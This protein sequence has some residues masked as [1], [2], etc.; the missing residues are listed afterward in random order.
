ME[1]I[2]RGYRIHYQ[3]WGQGPP[4]LLVPG[5]LLRIES[6]L[7]T[8]IPQQF[9]TDWRVLILDPLGQGRSDHPHRPSAYRERDL[10]EDILAVLDA[11]GIE[12]LPIWGYSRGARLAYLFA[13]AHPERVSGLVI[14]GSVA[15]PAAESEPR[16]AGLA[17]ALDRSPDELFELIGVK[18][19]AGRQQL[20]D[21]N[22]LVA[23]HA[24]L[25]GH[26]LEALDIDFA[27]IR[28]PVLI[29]AGAKEPWV[30]HL[31]S[32]A[33]RLHAQL[34]LLERMDHGQAFNAAD[35]VASLVKEFLQSVEAVQPGSG[36][37]PSPSA[38]RS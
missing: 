28:C 24:A 16:Y 7:E 22:D 33:E 6:W 35:E 18:D 4:L 17:A 23:V 20:V 34:H 26:A 1:A 15:R 3:A 8:G 10:P 25:R 21:N 14:G 32:D 29:Y 31:K 9:A 2:S 19:P 36:S 13:Q 5:A 27:A 37:T 12:R 11:E 30:D 38:S